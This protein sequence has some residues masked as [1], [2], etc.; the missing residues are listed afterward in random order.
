MA[1][2]NVHFYRRKSKKEFPSKRLIIPNEA[3][4]AVLK[5]AVINGHELEAV[6]ERISRLTYGVGSNMPFIQGT[7]D[8]NRK[9]TDD[10]GKTLCSG[11]FSVH[12]RYGERV[13]VGLTGHSERYW[14]MDENQTELPIVFYTTKNPDPLYIDEEGCKMIGEVIVVMENTERGLNRGVDVEF[15]FGGAEIEVTA[16]DINTREEQNAYF[17]FL[18]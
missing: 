6:T 12:V 18:G 15:T 3:G 16:Y 1:T 4:L 2:P 9:F 11:C 8:E 17:N 13:P 10:D 5:G 7:H 14:V